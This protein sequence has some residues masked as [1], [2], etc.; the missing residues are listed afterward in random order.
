MAVIRTK[1]KVVKDPH[2]FEEGE[3]THKDGKGFHS[4]SESYESVKSFCED[5]WMDG[6]A[7]AQREFIDGKEDGIIN[8]TNTEKVSGEPGKSGKAGKKGIKEFWNSL[9]KT[10]KNLVK[11]AGITAAT[12]LTAA[13]LYS[14]LKNRKGKSDDPD[15]QKAYTESFIDGYFYAQR[16][17]SE[18]EDEDEKRRD[19]NWRTAKAIGIGAG[20]AGLGTAATSNILLH[21]ANKAVDEE[22]KKGGE[23]ISSKLVEKSRKRTKANNILAPLGAGLAIGSV[24]GLS[25]ASKARKERLEKK[26]ADEEKKRVK[27]ENPWIENSPLTSYYKQ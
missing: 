11:G 5:A 27:E 18:E 10:Q 19:K 9:S 20:T 24:Y 21:R 2:G 6:Y 25:Q 7:L 22:L 16:E 4:T 26:A 23:N 13:G 8:G 14:Y 15:I 3:I 12:A 17:F 1:R